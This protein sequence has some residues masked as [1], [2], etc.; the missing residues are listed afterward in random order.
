[1]RRCRPVSGVPERQ[2]WV[3]LFAGIT[4]PASAI[5]GHDA[6]CCP[7]GSGLEG[8][9]DLEPD[10]ADLDREHPVA[11]VQ[12]GDAMLNCLFGLPGGAQD[13]D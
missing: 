3:R 7:T 2:V 1:M 6:Q 4:R 8:T 12:V 9:P 10:R 5:R 13:R 11:L